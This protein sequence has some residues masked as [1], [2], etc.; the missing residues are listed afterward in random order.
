M[1]CRGR[2]QQAAKQLSAEED[3]EGVRTCARTAHRCAWC[4]PGEAEDGLDLPWERCICA[5]RAAEQT[6]RQAPGKRAACQSDF[7]ALLFLWACSLSHGF[8]R[9]ISSVS[10]QPLKDCFPA[11]FLTPRAGS[12]SGEGGA[13]LCRCHRL[14]AGC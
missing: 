1:Q 8:S 13:A 11:G 5:M 6:G 14:A 9:H 4:S 10:S 2:V 12:G 7:L 3:R